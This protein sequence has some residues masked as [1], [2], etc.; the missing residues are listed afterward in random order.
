MIKFIKF[1]FNKIKMLTS[2]WPSDNIGIKVRKWI[3]FIAA[4]I[5]H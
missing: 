4:V 5:R 2:I 3:Y 1:F